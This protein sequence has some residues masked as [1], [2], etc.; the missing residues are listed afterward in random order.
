MI[1]LATAFPAWVESLGGFDQAMVTAGGVARGEIDR[2][3]MESR[4]VPGLFFAGEVIDVDGDS[5]GYNLQAAFS[6]GAL[7]AA[8]VAASLGPG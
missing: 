6:T 7:A 4:I 5:G 8:G 1:G 3:S 2:L